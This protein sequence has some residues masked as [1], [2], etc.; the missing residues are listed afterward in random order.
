MAGVWYV[1]RDG[2]QLGPFSEAELRAQAA[3]GDLSPEDLVWRQGMQSWTPAGEVAGLLSGGPSRSAGNPYAAPASDRLGSRSSRGPGG[4]EYAEFLPRVVAFI[5]DAVFVGAIACIPTFGLAFAVMAAAGND[6]DARSAASALGN[7]L[8]N[9]VGLLIGVTYYATLD[10]SA[11]QGTWGKQIMGIKVTDLEGNRIT[12]L[13]ALG[14]YFGRI[15]TSLTCGIGMLTPLFTER[16][17]TIH[18]MLA[19]CLALKR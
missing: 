16:K 8:A 11:K 10:S 12:F 7:C 4:D 18:D 15:V 17:Q 14:R 5:L 13:R 9:I 3:R 1:G 2:A 6:P 19:G